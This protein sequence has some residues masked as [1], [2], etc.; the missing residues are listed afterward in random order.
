MAHTITIS[1]KKDKGLFRTRVERALQAVRSYTIE[2]LLSSDKKTAEILGFGRST[3][4]GIVVTAANAFTFSAVFDA[5]NQGSSDIA[6]LP[7]NLRRRLEGG[8][9][10]LYTASRT[11][12]LLKDEPNPEMSA[13]DMRQAV[14]AHAMTRK[15]GFI[16]IERDGAGRPFYLWPITPDRVDRKR[17]GNGPIYYL[18]DGKDRIPARD[19]IDIR[20]LGYD[21]VTGYDVIDKAR[22]AIGLALAAEKF[23]ASFFG[24]GAGFPGL[25]G[26]K[27]SVGPENMQKLRD[28]VDTQYGQGSWNRFLIIDN[29]PSF[30]SFGTDPQKAQMNELRTKQVEEVARFFNFPVHK[31]KNLDRATNNNIEQQDL[32]YYKGFQLNWTIKW[33]Q[34]CTRKLIPPLESRQQFIKHNINAFLR[35]DMAARAAFYTAM[36]DRG[37]FC[38]DDV[39]E[40]EDLNPQP[41]GLGKVFLVNSTMVPKDKLRELMESKLTPPPAPAAT[42]GGVTQGDVTAANA[43]AS[44]AERLA[45]EMRAAAEAARGRVATLEASNESTAAQ[46]LEANQRAEAEAHRATSE[47]TLAAELRGQADTVREQFAAAEA[48]RTRLAQELATV[49]DARREDVDRLEREAREQ[50][51]RAETAES[52]TAVAVE[53]REQAAAAMA[54]LEAERTRLAQEADAV[55][56][57]AT[58]LRGELDAVQQAMQ[59][60]DAERQASERAHADAVRLSQESISA[61]EQQLREATEAGSAH[62]ERARALEAELETARGAGVSLALAQ[63]EAEATQRA[64]VDAAERRAAELQAAIDAASARSG[65]LERA[66][67]TERSARRAQV[68]AEISA[69]RALVADIMRRMIERETDRARRHQATPE[70]LRAW[71]D[72]FY[73]GHEDLMRTALLPAVRIHL[74]WIGSSDDA[75]D[76]AARLVARHVEESQRQVRLVLD[77]DADD[78]ATSLPALLHRWETTRVNAIADD[79]MQKELDHVR[80]R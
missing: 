68:S 20:G 76:V 60:A 7:L 42:D 69:H 19:M 14:Q 23:G 5:V 46:L 31:L 32:E 43:R 41:N 16:E 56:T 53:S 26:I 15:G 22:Q 17:D 44:E 45:E 27:S 18:I 30:T 4:S 67:E 33:E 38:A 11:Y 28:H 39:L 36:L 54:E 74:A 59:A 25:L 80:E 37:V 9:S 58:N 62:A 34:E 13:M 1:P 57:E 12:R 8:G 61:L 2:N 10:E 6:K 79:L 71:L 73:S 35:G 75:I 21:G 63:Q 49:S 77:G 51:A 55:R 64:A 65:E 72:T 48:E 40:L 24:S 52:A 70:K 3:D 78:I 29:D 50:S 66:L 47:E